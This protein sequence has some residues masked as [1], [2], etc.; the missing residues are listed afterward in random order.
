MAR[1][2]T[3]QKWTMQDSNRGRQLD[4]TKNQERQKR[5][6]VGYGQS[7]EV[8]ATRCAGECSA[9]LQPQ[10]PAKPLKP[11]EG[12]RT[13]PSPQRVQL[14]SNQEVGPWVKPVA[15]RRLKR[16]GR[17]LCLAGPVLHVTQ[18]GSTTWGAQKRAAVKPVKNTLGEHPDWSTSDE[19]GGG[20]S[21]VFAK[22]G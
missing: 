3:Q 11:R 20:K 21:V 18:F 8:K 7:G 12:D 22:A 2:T 9:P 16:T 17:D 1:V 15:Q 14:K 10:N 4:R 6:G 13:V 19:K 5:D